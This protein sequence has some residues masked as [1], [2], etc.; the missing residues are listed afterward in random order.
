M[1]KSGKLKLISRPPKFDGFGPSILIRQTRGQLRGIELPADRATARKRLHDSCP[2]VPGVYGWLDANQQLV[3]VGKSKSLRKRLLTYFAKTPTDPKMSRIRQHSQSLVWEPISN[4]LL[5]LIRETEL[6][7]R[8]RPE[9]NSQG[10]PTRMQPAFLCVSNSP[11]PNVFLSRRLSKKAGIAFGPI[12]G[13]NRLRGAI[14]SLNHEFK[15]RDC[16]DKT[17]FEYS[18][19]RQLF[20]DH[21]T[22]GC[23]R[24]ELGTCPAPCAGKCSVSDYQGNVERLMAFLRGESTQ[25]L[26]QLK[27]Q[28]ISAA[29][30][31]SFERAAAVRDNLNFL[32]WLDRR[33]ASLRMA[34]TTLNGILPIEARKNRTAWLVLRQ[35]R[36]VESMPAPNA[37]KKDTQSRAETAL[38]AIRKVARRK[39]DMPSNLL[40]MNLQLIILA[41]FR[42][43]PSL[44]N[45]ILSFDQAEKDCQSHL[46]SAA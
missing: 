33:L 37:G 13:T 8:W 20:G 38:T 39:S 11:A 18:N 43:H 23:I 26:E 34:E 9:F 10:Q 17:R 4:E 29:A 27:R 19:Q 16:P 32:S 41:W 14:E 21:K 12:S 44:K 22:A 2:V 7:H 46:V 25:I 3:Y 1:K 24:Y 30:S 35:G 45:S 28:M 5:A 15:L 42:K 31:Q 6:I 36:L 40:E